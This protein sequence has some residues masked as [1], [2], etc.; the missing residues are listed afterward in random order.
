MSISNLGSKIRG[1]RRAR[2]LTQVELARRL[3]ISASYLN[4]IEHDQRPLT[5][6][7]L[8]KLAT[9]FDLD[10]KEFAASHDG[11]LSADL[12]E[13]FSDP[14]F[15][16]HPLNSAEVR[17]L[18]AHTPK[19]AQAI[20]T[21]YRAYQA[22]REDAVGLASRVYDDQELREQDSGVLP[23]EEINDFIQ[24]RMNHIPE[25]ED[26]AQAFVDE[27]KMSVG[28]RFAAM[29]QW[30][31]SQ[32]I[33]VTIG[34]VGATEGVVRR[35]DPGRKR[36]YLDEAMPPRTRLFQLAV[37]IA[38]IRES[39]LLSRIVD[40][41]ELTDDSARTLARMVLANYYAG[42]VLMPYQV[43]LDAAKGVRYDVELLSARFGAG[44]EQICHRLTS[45]R[46]KGAEGIPFHM[47]RVDLAGNISKRFSA[48]GIRFARFSGSC[49]RWN[50]FSAFQTP[51]RVRIQISEMTDG[52]IF[53]CVARTVP[54]GPGGYHAPHTVQAV[55][56]GCQIQYA[57][58]MVYSDGID[59]ESLQ[60]VIPVGVTCRLCERDNCEQRV[61]PSLRSRLRLDENV[62]T[63]S[64]YAPA[65]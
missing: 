28:G 23:S 20:L 51:G 60:G 64:F 4:L 65:D 6:E 7:L 58:D 21:L 18:A 31:A 52:E 59:L 43:F 17:E 33:E 40:G 48:S 8:I 12:M 37:Q 11:R 32:G 34:Q 25:V 29:T 49:P 2:S 53:F 41:S 38:F 14:L 57:R 50:V 27:M 45:L 42:A 22:A 56:L 13:A 35:Y 26:A 63:R 47:I 19:T 3:G 10:L 15:E 54:K 30:L 44:F 55:G 9:E 24:R 61:L 62:R 36:V 5:A 46:R 39:A 16:D 1:Q